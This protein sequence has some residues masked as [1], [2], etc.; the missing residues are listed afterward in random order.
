MKLGKLQGI[1]IYPKLLSHFRGW[2]D[3]PIVASVEKEKKR[4]LKF[5][6]YH[7]EIP[8]MKRQRNSFSSVSRSKRFLFFRS[9]TTIERGCTS[10]RLWSVESDPPWQWRRGWRSSRWRL[11]GPSRKPHLSRRNLDFQVRKSIVYVFWGVHTDAALS[12]RSFLTSFMWD[13]RQQ[14]SATILKNNGK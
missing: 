8:R 6:W 7:N 4:K 14:Q 5:H 12:E 3:N 2:K 1:Q 10:K 13:E 9:A 11:L